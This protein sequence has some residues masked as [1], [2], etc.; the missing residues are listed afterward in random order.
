M[1]LLTHLYPWV[2]LLLMRLRHCFLRL[3]MRLRYRLLRLSMR[4]YHPL[5]TMPLRRH[6]CYH[7]TPPELAPAGQST[8]AT[9]N[10]SVVGSYEL[11]SRRW[12]PRRRGSTFGIDHV[13]LNMLVR[14]QVDRVRFY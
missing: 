6:L 12:L 5:L 13:G 7:R 10:S 4:S 11:L 14:L 3:S 1:R 8:V 2:R 9:R